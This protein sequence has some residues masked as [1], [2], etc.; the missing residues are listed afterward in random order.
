MA[1]IAC[2][3][4]APEVVDVT[5]VTPVDVCP[6]AVV[7]VWLYGVVLSAAQVDKLFLSTQLKNSTR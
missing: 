2:P 7:A 1:E 5:V 6:P 3:T 4:V